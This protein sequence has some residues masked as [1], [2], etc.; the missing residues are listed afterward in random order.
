MVDCAFCDST[1]EGLNCHLSRNGLDDPLIDYTTQ[2]NKHL[3]ILSLVH[4]V[5]RTNCSL[6]DDRV[7]VGRTVTTSIRVVAAMDF[8]SWSLESMRRHFRRHHRLLS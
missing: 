3:T 1:K 7:V 5:A 6:R 4:F 8:S 2:L